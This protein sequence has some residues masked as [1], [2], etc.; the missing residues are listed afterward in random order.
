MRAWTVFVVLAMGGALFAGAGPSGHGHGG[1]PGGLSVHHGHG[2]GHSSLSF[3]F[4]G[5]SCYFGSAGFYTY[6]GWYPYSPYIYRN[7]PGSYWRGLGPFE[8]TDAVILRSSPGVQAYGFQPRVA[9]AADERP[10]APPSDPGA[11]VVTAVVD[12]GDKCFARED[13]EV[14]VGLYR[15]ATGKAPKDPVAALAL[16]H[17]LFAMGAY[18]D[19]AAELRRGI[20]LYPAIV[21]VPMSRRDFY[22]NA[23]TYD[24]QMQRLERHVAAN[25]KDAAARF[26]LG[27]NYYFGPQRAKA[28]EQFRALGA[29]DPEAQLFLRQL[30]R[31]Q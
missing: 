26:L 19:A 1:P 23:E 24:A 13:F 5:G 11:A 15:L 8:Y 21:E 28:A 10:A 14:A 31:D 7:V 12:R 30:R 25:P 29:T 22:G 27:Y 4:S 17:G 20:R 3:G 16:G 9:A 18:A 6:Q 2:T